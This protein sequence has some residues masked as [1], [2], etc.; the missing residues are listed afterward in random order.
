MGL[1]IYRDIEGELH[2][3]SET[4]VHHVIARSLTKGPKARKFIN[5]YVLTPR[6]LDR[7]HNA[8]DEALHNNVPLLAPPSVFTIHCLQ[9]GIND[10]DSVGQYNQLIEFVDRVD[11]WSTKHANS[12]VR[13]ECGRLAENME[14]QMPYILQGQV[15]LC[16]LD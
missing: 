6:M 2:P 8:G 3:K 12:A 1:P 5:Q 7:F 16:S 4:S 11:Q 14:L 10:L 15:E 9:Q 13:K